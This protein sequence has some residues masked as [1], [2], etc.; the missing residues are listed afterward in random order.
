MVIV[1]YCEFG[2]LEN[3]LKHNRQHFI[4]EIVR[5]N[6]AYI[7]VQRNGMQSQSNN[8]SGYVANNKYQKLNGKL[9]ID[10]NMFALNLSQFC[11]LIL[12]ATMP[13]VDQQQQSA[14]SLYARMTVASSNSSETAIVQ[15]SQN[16]QPASSLTPRKHFPI[17]YLLNIN[18]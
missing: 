11:F 15:N 6:D 14:N 10:F 13:A 1:E 16:E 5:T 12:S 17:F 7:I 2:N 18:V 8:D 3:F 9:N 4:D